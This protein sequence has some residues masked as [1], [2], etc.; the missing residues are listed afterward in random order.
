[1]VFGL[2]LVY[3]VN[4]NCGVDDGRLDC[5]LLD[6]RLDVLVNVVVDMLSCHTSI[7]GCRV[8][9]RADIADI[10]ELCLLG[11]QTILYM[12]VVPV[13][14]VAV[15]DTC[16]LVG[17][18]FREDL[19]ILNGLNGGVEV[20][21]VNFA[22]DGRCHILLS[23]GCD[24]LVL[25]SGVDSLETVLEMH[26]HYEGMTRDYLMN[27]GIMLSILGHEVT[28]CCLCFLHVDYCVVFG[29]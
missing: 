7:G 1:V 18:L 9:C 15:L 6:D 22:V 23:G 24:L 25:Y 19:A 10:L 5:L 27:G 29:D 28:N 26:I 13:L 8:L 11:R 14:D 12:F 3:F 2:V 21:L 16:Y 20:V 17:V 4:R